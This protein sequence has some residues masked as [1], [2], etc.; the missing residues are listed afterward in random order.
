MRKLLLLVGFTCFIALNAFA[1]GS[2]FTST[3][4]AGNW[5]DGAT[6]GNAS[7]GTVG[8]D[9]PGAGDVATI[10]ATHVI[11]I[12][13]GYTASITTLT[14]VNSATSKLII[15]SGGQL[16]MAGDLHFNNSGRG[17]VDVSGILQMDNGSIMTNANVSRVSIL[18]GGTYRMNYTTGGIIYNVDFQS[19]ST[20]EFTGYSDAAAVAPTLATAPATFHHVTWNCPNQGNDIDLNGILTSI[21][22]NFSVLSTSSNIWWLY[23]TQSRP[24]FPH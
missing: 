7:P 1:A 14:I 17:K 3:V 5:N 15:S 2:P 9:F 12:P 18:T 6:W 22:G 20:L 19:G 11:T 23:L 4:L 24:T 16:N 21:N 8:T 13:G 10:A